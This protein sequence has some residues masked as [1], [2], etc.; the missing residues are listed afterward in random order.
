[1]IKKTLKYLS[2]YLASV[3]VITIL[4]RYADYFG[5]YFYYYVFFLLLLTYLLFGKLYWQ[6]KIAKLILIVILPLTFVL[7]SILT[8]YYLMDSYKLWGA[9]YQVFN[10]YAALYSFITIL[11][12]TV[13][14]LVKRV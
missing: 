6:F 9:P 3:F 1:M 5:R 13:C 12:L 11:T 7:V 4:A 14:F 10:V 8:A 2:I